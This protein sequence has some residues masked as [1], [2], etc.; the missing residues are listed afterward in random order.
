MNGSPHGGGHESSPRV[1]VAMSGGVDSSLAAALLLQQGCRVIGLTLKLR[2]CRDAGESRSCC[3][4]DSIARARAVAGELGIRHYVLD[5]VRQFEEL[6][7]RPSWEQYDSGRTPSPCLLCNER[8]KFGLLL[9]RARELGASRLATGHYARLAA[10]DNGRPALLRGVDR[11]K[12]QSYFLA[13]LGS[14][15]LGFLAFP[16]GDL[17]KREVRERARALGLASSESPESQDACHTAPGQPFPEMLRERFSA[18]SRPGPI[19]DDAGRR[20]GQHP[21]LHRYTIGQR[22]GLEL[23]TAGGRHWVRAIH[24]ESSALVV[25]ADERELYRDQLL[26]REMSWTGGGFPVGVRHCQ[27]Q[28]RSRHPAV[29]AVI[30]PAGPGSL[31]VRFERPVRAVTPGQAAVFYQGERVLGRGWIELSPTAPET[32]APERDDR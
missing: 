16:L 10:D 20:L 3:G 14:E 11:H 4:L 13:G 30:E 17:H 15:Q 9:D 8:I 6:V 24:A 7:L 1:V 22:R 12:D 19:L 32:D 21:G 5:C 28:V 18:A 31:R 27:V 25:T 23:S 29:P 2:E 26:A